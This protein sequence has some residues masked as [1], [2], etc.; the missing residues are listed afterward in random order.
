MWSGVEC[1]IILQLLQT[2][3]L[4]VDSGPKISCVL[5]HIPYMYLIQSSSDEFSV[6]TPDETTGK[7]TEFSLVVSLEIK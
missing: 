2:S 7:E 6:A 4:T 3:Y 5:L 1:S